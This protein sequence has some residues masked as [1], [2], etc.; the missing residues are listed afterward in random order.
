MKEWRK[1]V[2]LGRLFLLIF[3]LGLFTTS[4]ASDNTSS[5]VIRVAGSTAVENSGLLKHLLP[6]FHARHPYKI[7]YLGVGSGKALRLGRTGKVDLVWTHSPTSEHKFVESGNGIKRHTIMMNNYV[8][9]GPSQ[10]PGDIASSTNIYDALKRIDK[11]GLKFVSRADDSGTHKKESALWNKT[12]I[13]PY[14]NSW[15]LESGSDM[16]NS[17]KLA[18]QEK[19]Y[20]LCDRATFLVHKNATSRI[21]LED[22]DN[23]ANPY[24]VI[25]VNPKK[26]PGINQV[27]ANVFINWITSKQGQRLISQYTHQGMVLFTNTNSLTS[28]KHQ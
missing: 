19:A 11:A 6:S 20:I 24:S 7:E 12:G 8:L 10:D 1:Q 16:A 2:I 26:H 5:K 17:L 13:E 18:Q 3:L 9:V 14:G 4:Q 28:T 23:L 15:Y 25:A 27:G 21:I 22:P